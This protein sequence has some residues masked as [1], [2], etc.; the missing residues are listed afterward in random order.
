MSRFELDPDAVA[1]S[2]EMLRE[3]G[4]KV[5]QEAQNAT[6]MILGLSGSGWQGAA[7]NAAATKQTGEF[8]EAMNKMFAEI[9]HISEALGLGRQLT[10]SEDQANEQALNAVM[11]ETGNFGRL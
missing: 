2:E 9:N 10:A 3:T 7:M 1:R 11:P 8:T 5:R 6:N 4:E